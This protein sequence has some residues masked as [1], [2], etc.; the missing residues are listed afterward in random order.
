MKEKQSI[1]RYSTHFISLDKYT[2]NVNK[3]TFKV[4]IFYMYLFYCHL[5]VQTPLEALQ[6]QCNTTSATNSHVVLQLEHAQ[7]LLLQFSEGLAEVSPWLEETQTLIGQLSL[8]TISYEAFREQQDLLQVEETCLSTLECQLFFFFSIPFFCPVQQRRPLILH[9]RTLFSF[10]WMSCSVQVQFINVIYLLTGLLSYLCTIMVLQF[11]QVCHEKW[12]IFFK[13][14]LPI[15]GI[16]LELGS[17][18]K[19]ILLSTLLLNL[20]LH[21]C[22]AKGL[23]ESIAEHRPLIARLCSL[24]KRL[25]ELNPIQ[26]DEFCRKASETE[27]QHR[28]IRDRV[29]ETANLLE[30]SLPRFTQVRMF[31]QRRTFYK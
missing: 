10:R 26:G 24:A 6:E 21:L 23:R 14:P 12:F 25:S 22:F 2:D 11:C 4:F 29:R 28:A 16:K 8:S 3:C 27:E 19:E 17:F 7:S 18:W 20:Y 31:G 15:L 9:S 30:E 13:L 5:S 1:C